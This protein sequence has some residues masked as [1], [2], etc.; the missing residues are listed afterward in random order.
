[1]KL[2]IS[3]REVYGLT[4]TSDG[5]A[6]HGWMPSGEHTY[7]G[8]CRVN[9]CGNEHNAVK[10]S[11]TYPSKQGGKAYTEHWYIAIP[12]FKRLWAEQVNSVNECDVD[13]RCEHH[14][15]G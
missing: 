1:M 13:C 12:L 3:E 9:T 6:F 15:E 10:L 8:T 11:F 2:N 7:I 14:C 5:Q 4:Y